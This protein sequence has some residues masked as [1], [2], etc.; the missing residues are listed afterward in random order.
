M[1]LVGK[2]HDNYKYIINGSYNGIEYE[3]EAALRGIL[4]A[5]SILLLLI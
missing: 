5:F 1:F 4:I 2:N 3:T